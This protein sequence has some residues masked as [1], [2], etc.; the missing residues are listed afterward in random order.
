MNLLTNF[1]CNVFCTRPCPT[2]C[3]FLLFLFPLPFLFLFPSFSFSPFLLLLLLLLPPFPSFPLAPPS[4]SPSLTLFSS[5]PSLFPS[6]PS[7]SLLCYSLFLSTFCF[8]SLLFTSSFLPNPPPS[9]LSHSVPYSLTI[10][11]QT[12]PPT[13]S[14]PLPSSSSPP[15]IFS[16]LFLSLV[17]DR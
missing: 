6:L 15:F 12:S 9:V 11:Q 14:F 5:F 1:E 13:F 17:L 4:F 16:S 10:F 3:S 2:F 8:P 7:L